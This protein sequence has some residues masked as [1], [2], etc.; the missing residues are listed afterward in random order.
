MLLSVKTLSG[1]KKNSQYYLFLHSLLTVER[2]LKSVFLMCK[3]LFFSCFLLVEKSELKN[4]ERV[5]THIIRVA[6]FFRD[7]GRKGQHERIRKPKAYD[8]FFRREE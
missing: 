1:E 4:T 6:P 8:A 5:Q 7:S 3:E 2:L